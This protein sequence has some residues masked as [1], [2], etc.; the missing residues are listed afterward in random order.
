M[1]MTSIYN[2]EDALEFTLI[3]EGFN[4]NKNMHDD[5]QLLKVRLNSLIRG[6]AGRFFTAEKFVT[7]V[8]FLLTCCGLAI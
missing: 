2:R 6:E 8:I 3:S 4:Q 7:P 5:A 1:S